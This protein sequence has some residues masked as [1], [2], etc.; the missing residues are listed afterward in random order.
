MFLSETFYNH[1][2]FSWFYK[3]W[4]YGIIVEIFIV[5]DYVLYSKT[6]CL[7]IK[8][9]LIPITEAYWLLIYDF[10]ILRFPFIDDGVLASESEKF[11]WSLIGLFL[12]MESFNS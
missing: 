6:V 5:F 9:W 11:I 1:W 8:N 4:E 3:K 10:F 7:N 12:F 2:I